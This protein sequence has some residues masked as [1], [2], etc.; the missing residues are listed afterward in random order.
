MPVGFLYLLE[1]DS[2]PGRHAEGKLQRPLSLHLSGGV[3]AE[4]HSLLSAGCLEV[5]LQSYTLPWINI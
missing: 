4:L 3:E 5:A 1:G 2:L